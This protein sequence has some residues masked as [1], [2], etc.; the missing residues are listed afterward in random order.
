MPCHDRNPG[1]SRQAV[2]Y[3]KKANT[4]LVEQSSGQAV[5]YEKKANTDLVE[6][7]G[8]GRLQAVEYEKKANTDLVEQRVDNRLQAV[9]YEK[10]ANMDLVEQRGAMEK[11]LI[12]SARDVERLKAQ[13]A[14]LPPM[15]SQG[16]DYERR[17]SAVQ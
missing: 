8:E 11:N 14:N 2:E 4:D 16:S 13:I 7:R 1:G 5:E 9:E 10:K 17:E 6:Q 12:A 15:M 3:E